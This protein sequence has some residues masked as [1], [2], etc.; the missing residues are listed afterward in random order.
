M[1]RTDCFANRDVVVSVEQLHQALVDVA[2]DLWPFKHQ[3][4]HQRHQARASP[5]LLVCIFC[6]KDTA[7]TNDDKA[8]TIQCIRLVDKP[9]RDGL[10]WPATKATGSI[11]GQDTWVSELAAIFD[12]VADRQARDIMLIDN[13]E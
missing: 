2:H 1:R 7:H 13:G 9:R 6:R 3:R 10:R 4:C 12:E 5:D 11:V 8:V